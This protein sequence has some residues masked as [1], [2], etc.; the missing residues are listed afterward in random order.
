MSSSSFIGFTVSGDGHLT[1]TNDGSFSCLTNSNN[2]TN[3][4][5]VTT[6]IIQMLTL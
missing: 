2:D 4:N 3:V 1:C 5:D 6:S